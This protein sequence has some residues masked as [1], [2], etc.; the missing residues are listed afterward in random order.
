ME[1]TWV[2][3]AAPE[4]AGTQDD[5]STSQPPTAD[6]ADTGDV[7]LTSEA[8]T[9]EQPPVPAPPARPP[10]QRNAMQS[11]PPAPAPD[12]PQ[13]TAVDAAPTDSLSLMQL[14]RIVAEVHRA[15]QPAYDFEY[16]DMGPHAEEIDEWFNYQFWQ[17]VRLNSA[18][19]AF[20]WHWENE[21]E[22]SGKTWDD[23]DND[24]RARFAQSVI[25]GVQ[26]NDAALRSASIGKLVYLVLG[27]WGDT[28]MPNATSGDSQSVASISQLR[29][30]KAGVLCLI[31]LEGLPVI[32]E[33][34]KSS[35]E[36]HWY[37]LL[38]MTMSS[39]A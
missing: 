36:L 31:S 11:A 26:S 1:S 19:K 37:V 24:A 13:M 32:W 6:V 16:S 30:I 14:R 12:P 29:A 5:A 2:D 9:Q 23:A 25:A 39:L 20:E 35:F 38:G 7:A 18:Q 27:R 21:N 15:E 8:D 3:G 10:L 22:A 17:W 28:A 4:T 34:L 33:A